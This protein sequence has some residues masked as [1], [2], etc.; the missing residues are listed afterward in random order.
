MIDRDIKMAFI[1]DMFGTKSLI[2]DNK[3]YLPNGTMVNI[4]DY[5]C[6][7][8][9]NIGEGADIQRESNDMSVEY[10]YFVINQMRTLDDPEALLEYY[11]NALKYAKEELSN[12]EIVESSNPLDNQARMD[13]IALLED[14]ISDLS[15]MADPEM[16][17]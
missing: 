15:S 5:R 10:R 2:R 17:I 16:C 7:N 8:Y 4:S 6:V 11:T 3:C 1:N 9:Y 13:H 12:L 14:Q